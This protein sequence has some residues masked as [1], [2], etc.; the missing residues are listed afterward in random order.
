MWSAVASGAHFSYMDDAMDFCRDS[1]FQDKRAV[2][3]RQ[4]DIMASFMK[5][6]KPWEMTPDDSLVKSGLAFAMA[7]DKILFAYFP[8]GGEVMF[9]LS[10]MKG[11]ISFKWYDPLTGKFIAGNKIKKAAG[12]SFNTPDS[13]DWVLI[14]N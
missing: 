7:N 8:K 4:I 3:H 11:R 12:T 13:N 6:L 5:T 1:V 2:L 10:G 9:D 14:I